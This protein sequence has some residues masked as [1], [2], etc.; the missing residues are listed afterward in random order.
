VDVLLNKSASK[1]SYRKNQVRVTV[2]EC[3]LQKR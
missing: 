3:W 2:K 1:V